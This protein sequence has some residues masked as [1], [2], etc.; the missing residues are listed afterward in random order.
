MDD[1]RII[2]RPDVPTEPDKLREWLAEWHREHNGIEPDDRPPC[3]LLTK[4]GR[5]L[6]AMSTSA[7]N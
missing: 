1:H 7:K 3:F 5:Q 2:L 6:L 4:K